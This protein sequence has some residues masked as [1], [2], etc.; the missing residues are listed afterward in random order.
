MPSSCKELLLASMGEENQLTDKQKEK[1]KDFIEQPR[2]LDDFK[3]G[4]VVP[5]KL[6]PMC[7]KGGVIKKLTIMYS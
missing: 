2:T 7:I 5:S 4:L 1:Y 3:V 6:L